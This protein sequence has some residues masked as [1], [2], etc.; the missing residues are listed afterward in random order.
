MKKKS[1]LNSHQSII[2]SLLNNVVCINKYNSSEI[3]SILTCPSGWSDNDDINKLISLIRTWDILKQGDILGFAYQHCESILSKKKKGQYFTPVEIVDSI[4]SHAFENIKDFE[5]IKICDP[6]CG[7]GQFLI[8]AFEMLLKLYLKKGYNAEKASRQILTKNLFGYDID[9]T[10]VEITKYNLKKIS[11]IF[12]VELNISEKNFLTCAP[13]LENSAAEENYFDLI[14][15]NPP[16][17]SQL[18]NDEKKY[19]RTNYFSASSGINTFTLFIEKSL[20]IINKNGKI[21]FLI[22]DAYLNIKA[23]QNS[24]TMV[25]ENTCIESISLWGD[26]F[27][28]VYAP[29]ISINLKQE[30]KH[31]LRHKNIIK[32]YDY[33]E[34]DECSTYTMIPQNYYYTTYQNIFN[35]NY[36]QKAV[37]IISKMENQECLYLKDNATFF[38]GI[39]TGENG[40]HIAPA[41]SSDYPDP[42]IL[43]KD[44][45]P[46]KINFSGNYFKYDTSVLQQ[47]APRHLYETKNKFIYKFIGKKLIFAVD[48]NKYFTLN[49]VN[50]FIPGSLGMNSNALLGVL[51]SRIIQYY[52][53]K[54]FFTLKVLRNNLEKL[55][56]IRLSADSENQ[57]SA[58]VEQIKH[59]DSLYTQKLLTENIEDLLLYEYDLK[60][61]EGYKIWE[62]NKTDAAQAVLP[63]L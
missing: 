47:T 55:P 25:L 30:L 3:I 45:A 63:G 5:Q 43:G 44:V 52:Y 41:Y 27:I 51:N 15:G 37:S 49:N 6:A 19:F 36:S 9:P 32:I 48:S 46:Y 22:P 8:I 34:E 33:R 40:R 1:Y 54:N 12:D 14:T 39:V 58:Y 11:F 18:T 28:N 17:G 23:H 57:I 31:E 24:R 16:W 7:S 4:L 42:I 29:A 56:I 38:L 35:I 53:Q 10:A 20:S 2:E 59:T 61:N 50:G 60:D 26:P 62:E 21:A 13:S